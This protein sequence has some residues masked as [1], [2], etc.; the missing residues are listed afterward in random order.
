MSWILPWPRT[1]QCLLWYC[2]KTSNGP[3]APIIWV[4]EICNKKWPNVHNSIRFLK[5]T[6]KK[7]R[8]H[9]GALPPCPQFFFKIMCTVFRQFFGKKPLFWANMAPPWG[10]NTAGPSDQNP[11][12]ATGIDTKSEKKKKSLLWPEYSPGSWTRK[13]FDWPCPGY[14]SANWWRT[15]QG[16]AHPPC[17]PAAGTWR[18]SARRGWG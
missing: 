2:L 13:R 11:G 16:P 12:S 9:W 3:W 8:I 6:L 17:R 10:Q 7:S 14:G 1:K 18:P 5:L 15:L 4:G